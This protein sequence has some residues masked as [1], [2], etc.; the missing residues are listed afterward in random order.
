MFANSIVGA[1]NFAVQSEQQGHRMFGHGV[2]RI[3]RHPSH[4]ET[5]GFGSGKVHIVKSRTA[6]RHEFYPE[7][8]Q[9]FEAG[10]VEAV[11]DKDTDG[12][13]PFRACGGF[14]GK[15]KFMEGPANFAGARIAFEEFAIVRLGIVEG[16]G[17]HFI[18]AWCGSDGGR[19]VS[20]FRTRLQ[21]T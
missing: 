19:S 5:E 10:L 7:M 15:V 3:S 6:K 18:L 14:V 16:D 4:R 21:Q 20:T 11:V 12:I 1:M 9:M 17:V 13:R 2:R 8:V